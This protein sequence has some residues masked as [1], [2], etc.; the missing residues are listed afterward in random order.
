MGLKRTY[1]RLRITK[2]AD[3]DF[4]AHYWSYQRSI[5]LHIF[6][7]RSLHRDCIIW[8]HHLFQTLHFCQL[9]PTSVSNKPHKRVHFG[10]CSGRDSSIMVQKISKRF[11]VLE[12]VI[13][14]LRFPFYNPLECLL[15][16]PQIWLKWT[17][18]RLRLT[19]MAICVIFP[20]IRVRPY[21]NMR[22]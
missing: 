3:F 22:E 1:R 5:L 9:G 12:R 15:L 11:K 14:V 8:R 4:L 20:H 17:C 21:A 10:S 18:C 16:S 6:L 19:Q 2:T 13:Q 7:G